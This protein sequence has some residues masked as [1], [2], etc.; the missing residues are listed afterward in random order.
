MFAVRSDM[1]A[2]KAQEQ[3]DRVAGE[4]ATFYKDHITH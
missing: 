3:A 2:Q 4:K 1:R